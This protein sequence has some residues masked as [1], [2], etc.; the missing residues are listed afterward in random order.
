[1]NVLV[2]LKHLSQIVNIVFEVLALICIFSVKISV[3]LFIFHLFLDI[4]FVETDHTL[5]QL[6]EICNVMKAFKNIIF[7]LLFEALMLI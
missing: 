6:L 5:L 1:M 4:F 2:L 7:E 3:S